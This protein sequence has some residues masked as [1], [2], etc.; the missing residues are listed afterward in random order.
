[1][2]SLIKQK[3]KRGTVPGTD[4]T[5]IEVCLWF[6]VPVC[7]LLTVSMSCITKESR[8]GYEVTSQTQAVPI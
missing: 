4:S 2:G 8:L 3:R 7:Q 6:S 1:M 5:S